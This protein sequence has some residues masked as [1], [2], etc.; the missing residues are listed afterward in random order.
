MKTFV[1]VQLCGNT[2]LAKQTKKKSYHTYTDIS[3][4]TSPSHHT[5]L[6]KYTART[7]AW[8][9]AETDRSNALQLPTQVVKEW[10][11]GSF[12]R[13]CTIKQFPE[14]KLPWRR[15]QNPQNHL[16]DTTSES[17][18]PPGRARTP[19][20]SANQSSLNV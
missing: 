11:F 10:R 19:E 8:V 2:Q 5:G 17:A 1:S 9:D 20:S 4:P 3:T 13:V 14:E 15:Q 7:E 12:W 18:T 6:L 16:R